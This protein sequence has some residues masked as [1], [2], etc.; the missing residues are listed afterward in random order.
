MNILSPSLLAANFS[1]L[2][3]ELQVIKDGG[4]SYL[5][6]DVMDG[7]FVPSI[8]FGMPLI[9][10]IRSITDLLFD[11]HLMIDKPERYIA[12]FVECGAD[13]ITVHAESTN[14]LNNVIMQIKKLGLKAG[15][16]LNPSTPLSVLEYI[17]EY[18]DMILIMS[19]NPGSGGQQYI[20]N[21]TDKIRTL[22]RI[23][24]ERELK[25]D[26]EADGGIKP[27]NVGKILEAGANVIV[28]GSA[29]FNENTLAN[30]RTFM[31]MLEN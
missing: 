28:S 8:S 5:H 30:T 15:V 7:L 24:K 17:L 13:I 18:A 1:N 22:R 4:A 23:I 2:G 31:N 25:I 19:V 14:H 3:K 6:I 20:G 21:I 11:V 26:I 27:H 9:K 29:I 12:D 16:A 10:S